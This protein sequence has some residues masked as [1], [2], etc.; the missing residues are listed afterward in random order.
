MSKSWSGTG[1]FGHF[2]VLPLESVKFLVSQSQGRCQ[3]PPSW[4]CP[5]WERSPRS[6]SVLFPP[7]PGLKGGPR[8]PS[9]GS[10]WKQTA[11]PVTG[12]DRCTAR[13]RVAGSL[14]YPCTA[15]CYH[16]H[17]PPPLSLPSW[18][19]HLPS[20]LHAAHPAPNSGGTE[21]SSSVF[22]VK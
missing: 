18:I 10:A 16:N 13:C 1:A 9:H 11:A 7:G 5:C 22:E 2:P 8:T 17:T 14:K 4:W 21:P 15:D 6:V 12:P 19:K 3:P 20:C